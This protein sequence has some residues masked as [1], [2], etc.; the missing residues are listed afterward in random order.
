[1]RLITIITFFILSNHFYS[2]YPNIS[3]L[4]KEGFEGYKE[5]SMDS[6]GSLNLESVF[7]IDSLPNTILIYELNSNYDTTS[8]EY[9]N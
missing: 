7:Y 4:L 9:K 8:I 5:F 3:L 2:Q 1:M 6:S